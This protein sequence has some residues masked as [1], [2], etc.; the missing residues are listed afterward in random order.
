MDA[1]RGP[2][3]DVRPPS[4]R[5]L[6]A[7][8][9]ASLGA[10]ATALPWE[11]TLAAIAGAAWLVLTLAGLLAFHGPAFFRT[12]RASHP[13]RLSDAAAAFALLAVPFL[14]ALVL[15]AATR[16]P[17]SPRGTAS[18]G[19]TPSWLLVASILAALALPLLAATAAYVLPRQR[20]RPAPFLA[21]VAATSA[22]A[23]LP[24][25]FLDD[26]VALATLVVAAG[27]VAVLVLRAA[28]ARGPQARACWPLFAGAAVALAAAPGLFL[29]T[30]TG[31]LVA[32]VAAGAC[33]LLAATY[34]L[35]PVVMNA[36]PRDRRWTAA[37]AVA[38]VAGAG[39]VAIGADLAG[40][41]VAAASFFGH[42]V[43]VWPMRRPRRA[44][45]PDELAP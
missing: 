43:N 9:T 29:T 28:A 13:Y 12:R 16:P 2:R 3:L 21:A 5:V 20:K 31:G 45:P 15:Y 32:L 22:V 7:A 33:G 36:V 17:V 18:V 1:R 11:P 35:A 25:A 26:D 38:L 8:A 14:I 10:C 24:A 40:R 37:I 39:L 23:A 4:P 41:L 44:C 27:A 30:D 42:L 34:A 6:L 19:R